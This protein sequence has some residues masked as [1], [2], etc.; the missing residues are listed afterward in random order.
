MYLVVREPLYPQ[1]INNALFGQTGQRDNS[2]FG[3]QKPFRFQ[4]VP[5]LTG[6]G[7]T[8]EMIINLFFQKNMSIFLFSNI[9]VLNLES[10]VRH[11]RLDLH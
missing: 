8:K 5:S 4:R 11:C 6:R 1:Q 7:Q 10:G 2:F 9:F 3:T